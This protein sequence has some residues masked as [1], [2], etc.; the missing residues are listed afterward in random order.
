MQKL[1][2]LVFLMSLF[3]FNSCKSDKHGDKVKVEP[4][5][6]HVLSNMQSKIFT[7]TVNPD[8]THSSYKGEWLVPEYVTSVRIIGC[9][10]GNGGGGGGSGGGGARLYSGSWS[11][12]SWGGN[13][14]AGGGAN[15]H[16]TGPN[17]ETGHL[18]RFR[19]DNRA[20]IS[21]KHT[22][23]GY[24][25][26][27]SATEMGRAGTEGEATV[28]GSQVFAKASTNIKQLN[29]TVKLSNKF[30]DYSVCIGG[31]G[32]LGGH[33]GEGGK[34]QLDNVIGARMRYMEG[35]LGG[36]GGN[37]IS[38]FNSVVEEFTIRVKPGEKI[39]IVVG[40]GGKAG[41]GS[42]QIVSGQT[43]SGD[44]IL[45]NNG[46]NGASGENG[47]NGAPGILILEWIGK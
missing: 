38:G 35:G 41:Q 33:G 16:A 4:P 1:K 24:P 14:S 44:L 37:G 23:G 25:Q 2:N 27:Y 26:A 19:D 30:T 15:G 6:I 39:P 42:K 7:I 3:V 29:N 43:G 22:N 9:S 13:G 40:L 32:G 18:G 46:G 12:A 20:W 5:Q 34:A 21:L 17:G 8:G 47:Q 11:G 10:G 36:K 28:F 31:R 45:G